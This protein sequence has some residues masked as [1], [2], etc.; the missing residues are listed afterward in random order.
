MVGF[1]V[2]CGS[3]SPAPVQPTPTPPASVA[4]QPALAP[5]FETLP[6][7]TGNEPVVFRLHKFLN[8]VGYETDTYRA[9]DGGQIEAKAVFAYND[10]SALVPL[11]ASV[12]LGKDGTL[13]HYA[14]Y[15]KTSRFT[16]IDD[17]IEP[18]AD[19][20]DIWRNDTR[21]HSTKTD[22]VVAISGYAPMMLQDLALRS[23]DQ[24]GR[25]AKLHMLPEGEL[26]IASRGKE[27]YGDITLEHISISGLVWGV[28][29]AWLDDKG[30]LAA[31]ITRDAEFDHHEAC[32]LEYQKLLPE[33]AKAG[34]VD[35]VRRLATGVKAQAGALALVGGTV[36]D[37]TEHAPIANAVV[38]IEGGKITAAGARDQV[39]VPA[40]A[41]TIDATGMSILPGLWDMHAHVE[42]V[43]QG[44]VYLA[45]GV[46][47]V[48]DMGNVMPFITGMRDTIASGAG[49]GPRILV[50]GLVDGGGDS[51]IGIIRIKK[52]EDIAPVID[53]LKKDGALE[54]KIYSGI[55][56]ALV[57]P[58]V[59]YAHAHGLRVVGHVPIGMKMQ[60]AIDA[61]YDAISHLPY[62]MDVFED[63]EKLT[64]EQYLKQY[65]ARDLNNPAFQK[66][67]KSL[68]AR[69]VVI[70]DTIA[71]FEEFSVSGEAYA[72]REPGVR[73]LP[74]ELLATLS[75]VPA[76]RADLLAQRFD[77]MLD[78]VRVMH[79]AG[80]TF[81]A[82]TDIAVPGF[83][84]L[85]ELE[86]YVKAGFTPLQAIQAA[87]SVPAK[88]MHLDRE[89]GTV[90][91]GKRADL[92]I[93]RGNP[94]ADIS[95]IRKT[96]FVV[97]AGKLYE[98]P[99]LWK[100]AGFK[101]P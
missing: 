13:R 41:T 11:T 67:I 64:P 34:G 54:V 32:R 6:A 70:D 83:S 88:Y 36:I 100:L 63:D 94:L 95:D 16:A 38:V 56:P 68:V 46:T 59:K 33:L 93:V 74:R 101:Q 8:P 10:R 84:V 86:L 80:V 1:L 73:T 18:A 65:I 2:G 39:K 96:A 17:R 51:A 72:K 26:A 92:V 31:V 22:G 89:V 19:G 3:S 91:V 14:A 23:W 53:Q 5:L 57:P 49:L 69:H 42:Q 48:R 99:A 4:A 20:Y 45:A 47:T 12:T 40:N 61:G 7:A 87:T 50:D 78:V 81:V 28:E 97:A 55:D 76:S 15:G 52:R 37:G 98:S 82:G 77:K 44:A 9:R 66:E 24:R 43:E 71:L 85:R 60:Q 29:D 62:M 58:I 90:E 30:Q 25:P 75:D 27:T 79:A 21:S 35:G